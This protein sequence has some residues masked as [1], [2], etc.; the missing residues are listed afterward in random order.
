MSAS[1]KSQKEEAHSLRVMGARAAIAWAI[2]GHLGVTPGSHLD[3]CIRGRYH[4]RDGT[5]DAE[6]CKVQIKANSFSTFSV[7]GEFS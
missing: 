1:K 7:F 6:D 2:N 4:H 3:N 5:S